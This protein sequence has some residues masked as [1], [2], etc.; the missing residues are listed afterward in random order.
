M[1]YLTALIRTSDVRPGTSAVGAKRGGRWADPEDDERDPTPEP[2]ELPDQQ[3]S[4]KQRHAPIVWAPKAGADGG[5][6]PPSTKGPANAKG[7]APP[8]AD[9][10]AAGRPA[11]D[12]PMLTSDSLR[13]AA[14]EK[15]ESTTQLSGM[16]RG[17]DNGSS[18][19]MPLS[20]AERA[21]AEFE[22]FQRRQEEEGD[23]GFDPAAPP[24]LRSSPSGSDDGGRSTW[25]LN[26]D[27]KP[28]WLW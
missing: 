23:L 21:T 8:A 3:P 13:R 4:K 1:E 2:G 25:T 11:R 20:A 18:P 10:A 5:E 7:G 12:S 17:A 14:L 28:T 19:G 27:I 6:A 24:A 9:T 15:A 22:D 26:L 16:G